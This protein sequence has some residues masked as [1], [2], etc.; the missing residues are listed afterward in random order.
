MAKTGEELKVT[1]DCDHQD[2]IRSS[3]LPPSRHMAS[4]ADEHSEN[5]S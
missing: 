4:M 3:P 2:V 5:H 1:T